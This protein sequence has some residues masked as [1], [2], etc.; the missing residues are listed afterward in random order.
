[1][2]S[3][4]DALLRAICENPR[5]DTPRLAFA[6]W[7]EEHGE[8]DRAAFIRN[9]IAMSLRDEWD[10]ERLRWCEKPLPAV[11][12]PPRPLSP[13][14]ITGLGW[15][16]APLLYRGFPWALGVGD[17]GRFRECATELF[18][19]HPVEHLAFRANLPELNRLVGEPWFP[20]VTG[21][22]WSAGR[23]SAQTLRPLLEVKI[24]SL[25]ELAAHALALSPDGVRAI[26]ES[27]LFPKL[28]RLQLA[29]NGTQVVRAALESLAHPHP[30]S[31]PLCCLRSLTIRGDGLNRDLLLLACSLPVGLPILD[32]AHSRINAAAVRE[33]AGAKAV[34]GL[35][36]LTVSSN[37]F[38]NDGGTALF[39]SPHLAGLKVL[40]AQYCQIGD[41]ALRALLDDSPLADGLNL[42]DLTGSPA[43]GDMK[44]A[45]KDRMGDR[46][47][48]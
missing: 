41:D 45:V 1:M 26:F 6:D 39:T 9:D 21:L 15:R 38:G 20:R 3:D 48:I 35:R 24:A 13:K 25:T 18:A 44:Q 19:R 22:E 2:T 36:M 14:V 33:F 11:V 42:L 7:L 10:P 47:R 43:S 30:P 37:Q 16:N 23:Y 32:V 27:P 4:H 46:V 29:G 28:T 31:R 34:S 17:L 40:V 8:P 5:E 12:T